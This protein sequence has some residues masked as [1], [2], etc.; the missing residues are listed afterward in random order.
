M[1]LFTIPWACS[2]IHKVCHLLSSHEARPIFED[3][4]L[5]RF[6]SRVSEGSELCLDVV[7]NDSSFEEILPSRVQKGFGKH[8]TIQSVTNYVV[9]CEF[10]VQ[11]PNSMRQDNGNTHTLR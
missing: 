3:D 8:R 11:H 2:I 4:A 1:L 6:V 10:Y 5:K 7:S 9:I